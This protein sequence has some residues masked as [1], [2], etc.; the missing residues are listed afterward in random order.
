MILLL[1]RI[2]KKLYILFK[3][4]DE[5]AIVAYFDRGSI[6]LVLKIDLVPLPVLILQNKQ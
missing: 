5:H 1:L 2:F 3:S 4:F 6:K